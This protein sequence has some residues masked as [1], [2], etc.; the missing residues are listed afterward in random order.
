M[1]VGWLN[2]R[3]KGFVSGVTGVS[4]LSSVLGLAEKQSNTHHTSSQEPGDEGEASEWE[5]GRA[6]HPLCLLFPAPLES[7]RAEDR[8]QRAEGSH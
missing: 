8:G 4:Q 7:Q 5:F 2:K 3:F 6:G 1:L